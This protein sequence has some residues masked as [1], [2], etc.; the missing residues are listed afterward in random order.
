MTEL[1]QHLP[2][3]GKR[4]IVTGASKGIG[5]AIALA[6]AEAGA[7]V[8]ICARS[9]SELE[10]LATQIEAQGR[11]CVFTTCDVTDPAQVERMANELRTGL[12]G[13]HI[14]V[15]NAGIAASHKFLNRP[16]ELWHRLLAVNLTGVY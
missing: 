12:G 14:L 16:D 2:L 8:G 15:N 11:R 5:R 7:D 3:A 1:L 4:A 10:Q 13:V 9:S 6:L